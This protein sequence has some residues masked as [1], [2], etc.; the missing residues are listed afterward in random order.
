MARATKGLAQ[1]GREQPTGGTQILS[2]ALGTKPQTT[3]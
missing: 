3:W 2:N 1:G